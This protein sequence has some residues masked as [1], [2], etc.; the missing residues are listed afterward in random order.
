MKHRAIFVAILLPLI[1][2]SSSHAQPRDRLMIAELMRSE[3]QGPAPLE[4]RIFMPLGEWRAAGHEFEGTLIVPEFVMHNSLGTADSARPW[5][6][7]PGFS[8]DFFT[9]GNVL[10]PVSREVIQPPGDRNYWRIAVSP[11]TIW[12]EPGDSGL[13]RASFPFALVNNSFNDVH[14]GLATLVYDETQVS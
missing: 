10:V 12:S 3:Y 5:E 8:M 9:H 13:S 2:A 1:L 14:N 7:F 6:Y 4:N 11:G